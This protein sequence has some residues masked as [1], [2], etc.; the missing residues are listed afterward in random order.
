MRS[1][2]PSAGIAVDLN[3]SNNVPLFE[4]NVAV[5]RRPGPGICRSYPARVLLTATPIAGRMLTSS[6]FVRD[7]IDIG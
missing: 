4:F 5:K 2:S 7:V 3:C 1:H 6:H